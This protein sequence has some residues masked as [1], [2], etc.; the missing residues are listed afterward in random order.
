MQLP[1]S[2]LILSSNQ[3]PCSHKVPGIWGRPEHRCGTPA[4]RRRGAGLD[5]GVGRREGIGGRAS[6]GRRNPT[7]P[8][9]P[10]EDA[11]ARRRTPRGRR[12]WVAHY[13]EA[14]CARGGATS[15]AVA[16]RAQSRMLPI[17]CG[18]AQ[19]SWT[20]Y[21]GPPCCR[22]Y[23][24]AWVCRL[25]AVLQFFRSRSWLLASVFSR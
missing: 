3:D 22:R 8:V 4:S 7:A 14:C 5:H 11:R 10:L 9:L 24:Q 12:R 23:I 13:S 25:I 21:D 20:R 16:A 15:A 19:C 18:Q 1:A 2:A 17:R 6:P